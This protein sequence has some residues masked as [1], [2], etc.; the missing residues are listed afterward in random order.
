MI[1]TS[2]IITVCLMMAVL[3]VIGPN[4]GEANIPFLID[5]VKPKAIHSSVVYA[6]DSTTSAK[7]DKFDHVGDSG[8]GGCRWRG[9][10]GR[11]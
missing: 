9:G 5:W 6:S 11:A 1:L 2:F 4:E 8:R 7:D 3:A 10:G